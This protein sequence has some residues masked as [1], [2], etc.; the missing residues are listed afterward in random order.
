MKIAKFILF[1]ICIICSFLSLYV[2]I[3]G[4]SPGHILVGICLVIANALNAFNFWPW[5]N[6]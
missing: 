6:K 4:T 2:A 3:W 5:G 1:P